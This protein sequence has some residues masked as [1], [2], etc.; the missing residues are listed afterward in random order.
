MVM[1][2]GDTPEVL[3]GKGTHTKNKTWKF[4]V[5][6]TDSKAM[7][8]FL[9]VFDTYEDADKYKTNAAAAGWQRVAIFN[10][11]LTEVKEKPKR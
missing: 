8:H 9:G 7:P 1:N 11:S 6:G 4:A 3:G 10:P 2:T 5:I